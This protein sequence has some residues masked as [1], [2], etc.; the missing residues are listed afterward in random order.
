MS[1]GTLISTNRTLMSQ[2]LP[3]QTNQL[4]LA[5]ISVHPS[6]FAPF[7]F[8]S[9]FFPESSFLIVRRDFERSALV[10]AL[11]KRNRVAVGTNE[12]RITQIARI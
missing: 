11:I 8:P 12:P 7:F 4:L 1:E 3:T 5:V 2:R 10:C 9:F 6:S